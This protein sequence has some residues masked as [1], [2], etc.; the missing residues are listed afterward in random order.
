MRRTAVFAAFIT[1]FLPAAAAAAQSTTV[2]PQ[3]VWL[4]NNII[5]SSD[6]SSFRTVTYEGQGVREFYD[7]D[8]DRWLMLNVYLFDVQ[9]DGRRT[10]FQVHEE[11]GSRTAARQQ[12][13]AYAAVL[14]RLPRVL[15]SNAKEVEIS[16]TAKTSST[17]SLDPGEP[18]V[19][20]SQSGIFHIYTERAEEVARDGFL[21]EVLIHEGG[22]VSLDSAHARSPGWR[23]AQQADE[24]FITPFAREHSEREDI[25]ESIW[26][27][28]VVNYRPER[29]S[30]SNH[31][32]IRDGIPN[33]LAYFDKQQFDMSPYI[34][35]VEADLVPSF[36]DTEIDDQTW[37]AG[38][39]IEPLVLPEASGGD[40]ALQYALSPALPRGVELAAASRTIF[41]TPDASQ[42]AMTYE[43]KAT[44]EDGD[45]AVLTFTVRV[46]IQV[47]IPV[48]ALPAAG[49][50]LLGLLLA[51]AANA[52]LRGGSMANST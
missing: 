25:A 38:S 50:V 23:A 31:D 13:D 43:W 15:L 14:G 8:S 37:M 36:G 47:D 17:T 41:G 20:A 52:R 45:T 39:M 5:D 24:T 22:H 27:Y 12:V 2:L 33:R 34:R 46:D 29:I 16:I 32:A 42:A 21:E 18:V 26:A 44:D 48:P 35:R 6:P 7:R 28:F 1:V 51:A 4:Y 10:E 19:Q 40:G 9:F 49:S 11:Y 30:T 3:T